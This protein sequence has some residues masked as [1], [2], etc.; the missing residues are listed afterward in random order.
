MTIDNETRNPALARLHW[1]A[2]IVGVV[3]MGGCLIG[4]FTDPTRVQFINAYLFAWLFILGLSL[5]SLAIV[6]M[7]HL[8]GGDWGYCI[9]RLAEASAMTM[10]I[11]TLLFIPIALYP[12]SLFPWASYIYGSGDK[13]LDH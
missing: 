8:T 5:G 12:K 9:R 6:M 10:P 11:L 3:C 7:H 13:V 4:A 1:R 2:M